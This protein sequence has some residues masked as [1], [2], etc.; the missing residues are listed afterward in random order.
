[1]YANPPLNET[2]LIHFG[3]KGMKW[4]VRKKRPD[5]KQRKETFGPAAINARLERQRK[6]R[7]GAVVVVGALAI[8][9]VLSKRGRTAVTN[10][11]VTQYAQQRTARQQAAN[12]PFGKLIRDMRKVK[13]ASVPSPNEMMADARMAGVRN[14]FN[15]EGAQRLTDRAWRDQAR[16][17]TMNREMQSTTNGLLSSNYKNLTDDALRRIRGS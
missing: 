2:Y 13:A 12:N 10:S 3:K 9:L 8:G 15:R 6:I 1:M 17:A 11:A 14:A 4:G 16:L 7:Q 5:E